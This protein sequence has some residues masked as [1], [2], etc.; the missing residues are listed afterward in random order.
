MSQ[1]LR[2]SQFTGSVWTVDCGTGL[3]HEGRKWHSP[4]II[5]NIAAAGNTDFLLLNGVNVCLFSY[6]VESD[7]QAL[8][9]LYEAPTITANGAAL[10]I[11][12][13]NRNDPV[14]VAATVETYSGATIAAPGT[15]RDSHILGTSLNGGRVGGDEGSGQC[16]WVIAPS[17]NWLLRVTTV[18]VNT[19][20]VLHWRW[21]EDI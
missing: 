7:K 4:Y 21:C 8:V 13:L 20:I 15:F 2:T 1:I 12:N 17:S 11:I 16:A 3:V 14:G 9:Y 18:G 5:T 10:P 6:E 19:R